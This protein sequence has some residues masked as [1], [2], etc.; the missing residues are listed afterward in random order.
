M[1]IRHAIMTDIQDMS[2]SVMN[3]EDA[4]NQLFIWSKFR[5][6]PYTQ[7]R[8]HHK[9]FAF[10]HQKLIVF[11][12]EMLSQ[13]DEIVLKKSHKATTY[14]FFISQKKVSFLCHKERV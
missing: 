6:F 2:H 9:I 11:T 12:M 3:S 4:N 8:L 7:E 13:F 5:H 14:S 1:A 10:E